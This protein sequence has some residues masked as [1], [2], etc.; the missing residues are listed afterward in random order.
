M[1]LASACATPFLDEIVIE[2]SRLD[3]SF[4]PAHAREAAAR[5]DRRIL[6]VYEVTT[7]F[8]GAARCGARPDGWWR[9][10]EAMIAGTSDTPSN[11]DDVDFNRTARRYAEAYNGEM[12]R[13][14][15]G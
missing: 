12:S 8:P 7:L 3:P 14:V 15:C 4:A 5:G 6:G 11:R 13:I 9:H 10:G 2:R 1:L